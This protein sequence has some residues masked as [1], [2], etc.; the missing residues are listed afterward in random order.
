M[1]RTVDAVIF[2]LGR[3]ICHFDFDHL[4]RIWSER[5][6]RPEAEIRQAI[7]FDDAVLAYETGRIDTETYRRHAES[8]LGQ[9]L[10]ADTF[11]AGWN[12]IFEGLVPGMEVVVPATANTVRT[13]IL[14]NTNDL[15]ARYWRREFADVVAHTER[16][17]CS[18]EIRARK[19]DADAFRTVIDYLGLPPSRAVFFDD[20]ADFAEGAR[21]VGLQAHRTLDAATTAGHLRSA[22][23]PI[24][25]VPRPQPR[26]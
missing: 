10:P 18:H 8:C 6:D 7:V 14:S 9:P 2:D 17:F 23:I 4:F 13:V 19:P 16:E 5:L 24:P 22:G 12:G 3:V 20:I 11:E 1:T 15:H 21:A 26:T 25:D